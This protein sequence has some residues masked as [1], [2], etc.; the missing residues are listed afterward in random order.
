MRGFDNQKLNL[1]ADLL[2]AAS[3]GRWVIVMPEDGGDFQMYS[4]S[5]M[6]D[7]LGIT[8]KDMTPEEVYK[9]WSD[10]IDPDY[11]DAVFEVADKNKRGE[12]A[13][14]EYPWHHPERGKIYIKCG[15]KRDMSCTHGI[16][17]E[18]CHQDI[19]ELVKNREKVEI[20]EREIV[21]EQHF[22]QLLATTFVGAYY[23]DL[24]DLSSGVYIRFAF[25]A[26]KYVK[27]D[28]FFE[29]FANYVNDA[30]H[31]ED[32]DSLLDAVN[33]EY[34]KQRLAT[35]EEYSVVFRDISE[36]RPT[37]YRLSLFRGEDENHVVA[38]F[39]DVDDEIRGEEEIYISNSIVQ[40]LAS[41][42]DT[43]FSVNC[44]NGSTHLYRFSPRYGNIEGPESAG[45]KEECPLDERMIDICGL[46]PYEEDKQALLTK[47]TVDSIRDCIMEDRNIVVPFRMDIGGTL[48][49]YEMKA[50][51]NTESFSDAIIGIRDTEDEYEAKRLAMNA[52]LERT[53]VIEMLSEDYE[54]VNYVEIGKT[55]KEDKSITYRE[56]DNI[57][58]DNREWSKCKYFTK[59]LDIIYN[60][61]VVEEDKE[62]F[63]S[64]TRR[65]NLLA[66]LEEYGVFRLEFRTKYGG[67]EHYLQ[68]KFTPEIADSKIVGMVVGLRNRDHEVNTK[69]RY[70]RDIEKQAKS[71]A[72]LHEM[73]QSGMWSVEYEGGEPIVN[74]S[75]EARKMIGFTD[76]SEFAN[77]L[78]AWQER[79]H[80]DDVKYVMKQTVKFAGS[81]SDKFKYDLKYRILTK[82]K[83]YRWF[84]VAGRAFR[85]EDGT[86][87]QFFG[88]FV[89][90]NDEKELEKV[91][92]EKL[93]SLE[94]EIRLK[95]QIDQ[96]EEHLRMFHDIIHSGMWSMVIDA[97][98]NTDDFYCSDEFKEMIGIEPQ[99]DFDN[100]YAYWRENIHPD[101]SE[102]A[103]EDFDGIVKD[104]TGK[105]QCDFEYRLK[106][107]TGEW[108]WY[109]TYGR[110]SML[111]DGNR[112]FF[113]TLVDV[114]DSHR[115]ARLETFI[116]G[117][118]ED[119]ACVCSVD[120]D[121]DEEE[122]F[123]LSEQYLGYF[124]DWEK[125]SDFKEHLKLIE[126]NLIWKEDREEFV[127]ATQKE[128]VIKALASGKSHF[129]NVRFA[130]GK[131]YEYWQIKFIQTDDEGKKVVVGFRSVDEET[132]KER[133]N[134]DEL[135][136]ARARAEEANVA[137]SRFLF[138]MSH[139]IRT[140]MNA[141]MGFSSM[142]QKYIDDTD[143]VQECLDKVEIAGT[144]L[145]KLI[146]D[147]LDMSRIESGKFIIKEDATDIREN[148]NEL[149]T[150]I[151]E[152]AKQKGIDVNLNIG[153]I[154]NPYVLADVL[155][156]NQ[157]LLNILSNAVK[158]TPNG[159]HVNFCVLQTADANGLG[160]APYDFIFED[161]G[162]GMTEELRNHVFD[163]FVRAESST[164]SGIQ[165]T[166]LGMSIAKSLVEQMG[167]NIEVQSELD[168]GTKVI[169]H[170]IFKT[171]SQINKKTPN[172][173]KCISEISF[174][175]R[176]IL[177]VEDNELN[178][179]I[180][181]DI[182]Q[183]IGFEVDTAEDGTV[184]VDKVSKHTKDYYDCVLMD[185]QM[186]LM[187]GY[188]ATKVIRNLENE[189]YSGLPIFAMTANAFEEDRKNA[190]D[191]GMNDHLAKPVKKNELIDMLLR[192][193][194]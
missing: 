150:I 65:S 175:G 183:E 82:N 155:H 33:P 88:I 166:G 59:K 89:D 116:K 50:V 12:D 160:F 44:A 171:V 112:R 47:I 42:I 25:I 67:L 132:R 23:I 146:N 20:Q 2:N 11:V 16:R 96:D 123:Q 152:D 103:F 17:V 163:A 181:V 159:G 137:K 119:F 100:I 147:V 1:T 3:I 115:T 63:Y 149:Y 105:K 99:A 191:A 37:Y 136:L 7:L 169:V 104:T 177:L 130:I 107:G 173:Q 161:D 138:N 190:L 38:G 153:D 10:R 71:Y 192:H 114:T 125:V 140:P 72:M 56:S 111:S 54:W 84:R 131:D 6:D 45:V 157:V 179:E 76:E 129:V 94:N 117:L 164:V 46:V 135:R 174:E 80:P 93:E 182:L 127:K 145:L 162:I 193:K 31:E 57:F 14:V 43:I 5:V 90:I 35:D 86:P 48:R 85:R 4:D 165:G 142:A 62:L 91:T 189:D 144:H 139:D 118:S 15:G 73:I 168:V 13:F 74:W 70:E 8:G 102:A 68:M 61:Y 170:M 75:D 66:N 156:M 64:N 39:K 186:P 126:K 21:R 141:I 95:N 19:T 109:H 36:G 41:D 108:R 106:T 187:D 26:P 52:E 30:V 172:T 188:E 101:D 92:A 158:Y 60:N 120:I 34:M 148:A 40:T 122:I 53:H 83:G 180:A 176:K 110:T 28:N 69:L 58:N 51:P 167:G 27:S 154:E 133:E 98:G 97:N 29:T 143:K 79:I 24:T 77:N 124:K 184:A 49:H 81:K 78:A 22:T 9:H 55:S 32:R 178:R 185:I 87:F 128:V 134:A 113:G 121:S 151:K 194:K 18:G